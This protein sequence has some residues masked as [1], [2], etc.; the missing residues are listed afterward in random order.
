MTH[1]VFVYGSLRRG[2]GNNRLL[3]TSEFVGNA[4]VCGTLY[5]LGGFPGL[6]IDDSEGDVVGEVWQVDDATLADLDRLEGVAV[7]FYERRKWRVKIEG[8]LRSA[9]L[10]EI[11]EEH[12]V[13]QPVVAGGDWAAYRRAALNS[14]QAR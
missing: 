10:Y 3:Y 12:I 6:R 4:T 13:G 9:W 7:G 5:S 1:R 14:M 2:Q 11:A 8:K